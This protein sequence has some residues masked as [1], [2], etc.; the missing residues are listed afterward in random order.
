MGKKFVSEEQRRKEQ[1][2]RMFQAAK[3]IQ[4][5]E[6][7]PKPTNADDEEVAEDEWDD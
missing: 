3:G 6:V 4:D 5:E 7:K 2:E 1:M